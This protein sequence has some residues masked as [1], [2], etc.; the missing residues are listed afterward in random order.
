MGR[1]GDLTGLSN[2]APTSRQET[3]HAAPRFLCLDYQVAQ[4]VVSVT[5]HSSQWCLFNAP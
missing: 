3:G 5:Q 1:R 4:L 2:P